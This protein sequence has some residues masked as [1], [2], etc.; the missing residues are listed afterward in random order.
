MSHFFRWVLPSFFRKWIFVFVQC[1]PSYFLTF[2][3]HFL[4]VF[5]WKILASVVIIKVFA[6]LQVLFQQVLEILGDLDYLAIKETVSWDFFPSRLFHELSSPPLLLLAFLLLLS[7]PLLHA[8]LLFMLSLPCWHFFIYQT[9][10]IL[11]S[12][13]ANGRNN[14]SIGLRLQSIRLMDIGITNF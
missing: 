10:R 13:L 2:W 1:F 5:I 14:R 8:F 4:F 3:L 11:N 6:I 12:G 9:I 7:F